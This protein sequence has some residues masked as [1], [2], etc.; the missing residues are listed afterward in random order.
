VHGLQHAVQPTNVVDFPAGQLERRRITAGVNSSTR[1]H[2]QQPQQ[3]QPQKPGA[4]ST[5]T[6]NSTLHP[7][8]LHQMPPPYR[9]R[10]DKTP[11]SPSIYRDVTAS[12]F[13]PCTC[14]FW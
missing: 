12:S 2:L 7:R 13:D 8:A 4:S 9:A 1:R 10:R 11:T 3:Q 5:I 14:T 6:D